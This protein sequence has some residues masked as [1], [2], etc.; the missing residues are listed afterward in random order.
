MKAFVLAI[1]QGTTSSRAILYDQNYRVK[2]SA[3]E[4]LNQHFPQPGWVEHNPEEI[5]RTVLSVCRTVFLAAKIDASDIVSI[6]I[7]NQRETSIIWDRETGVPIYNAIVWQDRRTAEICERYKKSGEEPEVRE[8][9]GLLLDSYFSATKITWI[10]DNVNGARKRAERGELVFGTVDT[11]LLW[12]FT[13][14]K[15]HATDATN[16]SRTM[17][18]NI[19]TGNW[20]YQ[21]LD[22]FRIPRSILPQ[23]MNSADDFGL[24]DDVFFGHEIPIRSIAGDQQAA[25]IGQ[26]CFSPGMIKSTFGTGSF[27]LLNTGEEKVLSNNRMLTTIAYQLEGKKTYALEGSV[28]VAGAAIHWLRDQLKIIESADQ[29]SQMAEASDSAQNIIMIPAFTGLGAP[30]WDPNARGSIFGLTRS[31]GPNEIVRAAL[32]AVCFQTRDLLEA[33]YSDWS[34]QSQSW[35]ALR[36]DGG[37]AANGW[38]MQFLSNILGVPVDCP[39][40]TESTALGVAYLAGMKVGFFPEPSVFAEAWKCDRYFKPKMKRDISEKRYSDWKDAVKRTLT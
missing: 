32:E 33:M 23:I 37:M 22:L 21:L 40:T 12:R 35:A 1:D 29:S 2:A 28:F 3:Q 34:P 24:V 18:C 20:D 4:E 7:A 10:L 36:A 30:Y 15:V 17:L 11:F 8:K 6:G 27:V 16:A 13:G 19:E 39:L 31:T 26:A 14:G 25:T 38:C 5:W 9:T